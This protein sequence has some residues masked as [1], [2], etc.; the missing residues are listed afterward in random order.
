MATE[1]AV[2]VGTTGF[3]LRT[4][5]QVTGAGTVQ[6]EAISIVD[7]T[8]IAAQQKVTNAAPSGTDYGS[9]VWV[10]GFTAGTALAVTQS[11]A[12]NI[13]NI[14]GTVSLPT[15]ASTE[16]TLALIKAKT[17]NLDVLLS[18]R[19]KPADTLAALTNLVQLNGAAIAMN[20]GLRAAGVQRVTIATDDLVPISD[21]AG[22]LTVDAPVGT[23]V[24][25]R[26][27]D[28][29][30]ALIGQK[31]MAA[32]LPVALASDQAAIPVNGD[33]DHDAINTLK[34]IQVAGHASPVD[35]PPTAVSANGD[36]ARIWVD[37]YG[38]QIV[39]RRKIRESYTAVFRLGEAAARLDGAG[40]LQV[41]NTNKQWATV[42]HT[43]GAT[44]EV[45]LEYCVVYITSWSVATQA[46]LELREISTAPTTG[47]P[48]ITPKPR[49]FGG[50]PSEAVCLYLP[51]VAGTETTV[52]SPLKSWF[53]D[54]GVMGVVG[55]VNPL[56]V[57][58]FTLYN[59]AQEDDEMLPPTLP[60]STLSGWALMLR[61]VGAPT[62]RLVCE[63]GFTE[64]IP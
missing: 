28:G 61:C 11:G 1:Q 4:F 22:S 39:R 50:S 16:A 21:N 33:V 62:V 56:P 63:M 41:A 15:G 46:I 5:E 14:S 44:K 9:V 42:H 25:A 43:A 23:P 57:Q 26:L 38:A 6:V 53:V 51:A 48:A 12:W 31:A 34:N 52:N 64:E 13:T 58:G 40:F 17:D 36:R 2:P 30:A 8:A 49:R 7:P 19:L 32:S 29:A 3:N 35:I 60:V 27:S 18:T 10:Q 20:T 54:E 59:S 37:R 24:F 45:R 55:T 47:A